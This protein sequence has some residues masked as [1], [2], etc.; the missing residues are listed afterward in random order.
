MKTL[1]VFCQDV[2]SVK[3]VII[4][5]QQ[6]RYFQ[7]YIFVH[8][9]NFHPAYPAAK[10]QNRAFLRALGN[11]S[12]LGTMKWPCCGCCQCSYVFSWT[13]RNKLRKV[14]DWL[15]P[16]QPHGGRI[17]ARCHRSAL[18]CK[19]SKGHEGTGLRRRRNSLRQLFGKTFVINPPRWLSMVRIRGR[20]KT[21]GVFSLFQ[22]VFWM[23]HFCHCLGYLSLIVP[24]IHQVSGM[25]SKQ[26]APLSEASRLASGLMSRKS[27]EKAS[28]WTEE[29]FPQKSNVKGWRSK[30]KGIKIH[31]TDV[32]DGLE[33][34]GCFCW[35][36]LCLLWSKPKVWV[37][38]VRVSEGR[39]FR[40]LVYGSLTQLWSDIL[41]TNS[42]DYSCLTWSILLHYFSDWLGKNWLLVTA[43][44]L[45]KFLPFFYRRATSDWA[46]DRSTRPLRPQRR[47]CVPLRSS[48][49]EMPRY[50]AAVGVG[51]WAPFVHRKLFG[52]RFF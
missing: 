21:N 13:W 38:P 8:L 7:G 39:G 35:I 10:M 26:F 43:G 6:R 33:M 46:I 12:P 28:T 40:L 49:S 37:H 34:I 36:T 4:L 16:S 19:H 11:S 51:K 24:I 14:N 29:G 2:H 32:D 25:F 47:G 23:P 44:R 27:L 15:R 48:S 42:K 45:S 1:H 9:P 20:S 17:G 50:A 5:R 3:M 30:E 31:W 52:F 18:R 22:V 41:A